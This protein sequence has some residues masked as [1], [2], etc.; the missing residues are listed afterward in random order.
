M[1]PGLVT[2]V[3][4][5]VGDARSVLLELAEHASI[6]VLG[7][8]G[9]GPVAS[10]LLGSVCIAVASHAPCAVAVVR[11]REEPAS[12]VVVGVSADD[13]DRSAIEFAAALASAS[14]CDLELVHGWHST[15]R[16]VEALD[17][18]H[19]RELKNLHERLLA[20]ATSGLSEKYPDIR[21]RRQMPDQ[22]P[23]AALVDRSAEAECV[24]VGTRC[25]SGA[26]GL[27]GS[28][29]RGVIEHAHCTVVVVRD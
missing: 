24:V 17:H 20:E 5:P 26:R 11:P 19:H 18:E 1:A 6:I 14:E 7:T 15:E 22:G 10:L 29:S 12:G 3:I 21:V 2:D 23:V 4:T 8:R 28:V 9:H 13:S 27:L 25:L 16:Y